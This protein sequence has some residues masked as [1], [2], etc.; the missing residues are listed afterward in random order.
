MNPIAIKRQIYKSPMMTIE[1]MMSYEKVKKSEYN[2]KI[3]LHGNSSVLVMISP[4]VNVSGFDK[5][6]SIFYYEAVQEDINAFFQETLEW[7]YNPNMQDLFYLNE[8]NGLEFNYDY[9]NLKNTV[10]FGTQTRQLMSA[11]PTKI[12]TSGGASEGIYLVVNK[13]QY[14][15]TLTLKEL[16]RINN[17]IQKFNFQNEAILLYSIAQNA[18]QCGTED[19]SSGYNNLANKANY[20]NN[21]KS[22]FGW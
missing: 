17:V 7:F 2:G 11:M 18:V 16:K 21:I 12:D 4:N 8:E 3:T 1:S 6:K 22:P 13:E 5:Q 9:K 10:A 19:I 14:H 15:C 20:N